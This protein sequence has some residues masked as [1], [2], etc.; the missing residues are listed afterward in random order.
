MLTTDPDRPAVPLDDDECRALL[1]G[2]RLG[3]LVF[4]R[5]ALPAIQP[6]PYC[7]HDDEVVIPVL[8]DSPFVPA[9]RGAVVAFSVDSYGD[10]TP[11]GDTGTWGA[12][13]RRWMCDGSSCWP[14][15]W[16][17]C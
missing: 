6:V 2:G 11:T 4:T 1:L 14:S 17:R 9:A 8:P 12:G 7:V 15:P 13:G 5:N 16:W 3:R 10:W